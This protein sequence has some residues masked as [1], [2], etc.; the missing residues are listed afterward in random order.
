VEGAL[1]Q[2]LVVMVEQIEPVVLV[3]VQALCCMGMGGG[4]DWWSRRSQVEVCHFAH[5]PTSRRRSL[6]R[7]DRGMR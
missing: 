6:A 7:S 2:V 3:K 5:N 4:K 1:I